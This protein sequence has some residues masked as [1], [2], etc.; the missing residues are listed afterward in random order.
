MTMCV[1][2]ADVGCPQQ[3]QSLD[4]VPPKLLLPAPAWTLKESA[5]ITQLSVVCHPSPYRLSSRDSKPNRQDET[6][7]GLILN[8]FE[9]I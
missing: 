4:H 9:N 3:L 2:G 1:N 8:I 7:F 6:S 5:D